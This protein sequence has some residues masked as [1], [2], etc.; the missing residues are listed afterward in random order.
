MQLN[1][2]LPKDI[3]ILKID[4]KEAS[5]HP[6]IDCILKEY[7]YFVCNT[8]VQMPNQRLYS[9]HFPY[10]LDFSLMEKTISCLTGALDFEAFCNAKKSQTYKNYNR[11]VTSIKIIQLEDSRLCFKIKGKNFLYKMVRNLVGTILYVGC[12]KLSLQEIEEAFL[13]KERS[14]IGITAKAHG[15]TLYKIF[16]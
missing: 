13:K 5:F 11:E 10:T 6:T 3:S 16:Y 8:K 1:N 7:H 15:L 14:E 12:K 9:W 2:F 4:E